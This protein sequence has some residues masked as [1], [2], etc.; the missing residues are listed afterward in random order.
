M[1]TICPTVTAYD[2]TSFREQIDK[3]SA[4]S[5][6]IHL[7]FMDGQFAPTLSPPLMS[8]HVPEGHVIDLHLMFKKPLEYIDT[9][10]QLSP[11]M[12]I[13][14]AEAEGSY[15]E[16]ITALRHEHIK[17]GVSLLQDTPAK[18]IA[19]SINDIDHVLIFSGN[20]GHY[21][22]TADLK[23]LVKVKEL[24]R[25]KP[26]IEIGWDGGINDQNV[27]QLVEAG[28]DILNVG[29]FIQN[30]PDPS[31]AYATLKALAEA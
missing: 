18:Q 15:V 12:V 26:T 8:V 9:I 19:A 22:G 4:I 30:A 1:A 29:G 20:L 7:D 31:A 5:S 21:G 25:L 24:R 16:F 28:V 13:I 3:V 17:V 23:L 2:P 6:R 27:K 10:K 14:H 11:N